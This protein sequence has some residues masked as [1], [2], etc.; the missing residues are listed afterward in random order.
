MPEITRD[1]EPDRMLQ[2]IGNSG[3]T[4]FRRGE[5]ITNNPFANMTALSAWAWETGWR[6]AR[7]VTD[8]TALRNSAR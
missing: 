2:I 5:P 8:E 3:V 4:A 6:E 1:G 7:F